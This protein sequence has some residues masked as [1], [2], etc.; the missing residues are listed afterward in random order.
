MSIRRSVAGSALI[1][2]VAI[3]VLTAAASQA[4]T[5]AA[6]RAFGGPPPTAQLD[7][8][9]CYT[10]TQPA[11]QPPIP[12]AVLLG[13]EFSPRDATGA[14][15]PQPV[16][17]KAP[18]RLCAPATK[19]HD[20]I[21]YPAHQPTLHLVCFKIKESVPTPSFVVQT[22]NQF[23]PVGVGRNLK[24]G[25]AIDVCLPS[26]KSID[27]AAPPTG[28]PFGLLDHFKCYKAAETAPG[29]VPGLPAKVT[30][31]D[32]FGTRRV[33]VV[34]P[35]ILCNPAIK[36]VG[37]QVFKPQHPELHLVCFKISPATTVDKTV[38]VDNQFNPA[39]K[40]RALVVLRATSLCAPSFKQILTG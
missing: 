33:K 38:L 21:T 29:E 26:H 12:P 22:D 39:Q 28:E 36:V 13:D 23:N 8:F 40:Y 32:Q 30:V 31:A 6:P 35:T 34:K 19:I 25:A 9:V 11:G 15:V 3:G 14:P 1:A 10:V 17:V 16:K 27:P 4:G 24:T 20:G 18:T 37:D 5:A 2:C 7:H